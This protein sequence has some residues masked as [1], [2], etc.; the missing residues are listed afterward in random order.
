MLILNGVTWLPSSALHKFSLLS[1]SCATLAQSTFFMEPENGRARVFEQWGD[2]D[3]TI[4]MAI[5]TCPVDC[6]YYVPY[7]ELVQ[8][9]VSRRDQSI[10]VLAG[11]VSRAE[12]GA[13]SGVTTSLS[14]RSFGNKVYTDAP[15]IS[16]N[17]GTRCNN[18]PSNGCR[19]CPMYG[20]GQ[21]PV[22]EAKEKLR[23]QKAARRQ[24]EEERRR[25]NKIADL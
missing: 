8:L 21:N 20:I 15:K 16:G 10:N 11:L 2:D 1:A 19:A 22:F 14:A 13:G 7:E 23:L 6:I 18:C 24:L 3:N 4:Q 17:A 9:E 5:E 12:R 25:D